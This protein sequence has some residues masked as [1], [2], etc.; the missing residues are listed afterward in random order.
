[1]AKTYSLFSPEALNAL[2]GVVL[3]SHLLKK[4]IISSLA[5]E[6]LLTVAELSQRLNVSTPT[7][8]KLILELVNEGYI[9]DMGKIETSGGRRPVS[10]ALNDD[11]GYFLGV[12]VANGCLRFAL[13]DMNGNI[14]KHTALDEVYSMSSADTLDKIVVHIEEA[15]SN[16]GVERDKILGQGITVRGRVDSIGGYSYNFLKMGHTPLSTIM[17]ERT[18][19]RTII[20]NDTRAVAF[21]EYVINGDNRDENRLFIY[22]DRGIGV[23]IIINGQLYYGKS[24][25][26]GEFGHIPFFDNQII[27]HCGKKGCLETEASGVA[28]ENALIKSIKEGRASILSDKVDNNQKI[29]F[30]EIVDAAIKDDVLCI[31]LLGAIGEKLGRGIGI[32][33]NLFNPDSVVIGGGLAKAGDYLLLPVRTALA[34]Y[35]LSLVN[36][37]SQ[38]RLSNLGD[39]GGV[40]GAALLTRHHILCEEM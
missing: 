34:K 16:F 8:T 5:N 10:F 31:E 19:S 1:M 38:L 35:S 18:G 14:V 33:M 20:E 25:F 17:Y 36:N 6:P 2:G 32:L 12:E 15:I 11:S 21:A 26:S 3:K 28:L 30:N 9:R 23:G 13:C 24:G 39:I 40:V 7:I 22:V 37:D 27:C 4:Q 29:D